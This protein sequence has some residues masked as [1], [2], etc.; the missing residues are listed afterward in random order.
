MKVTLAA[1]YDHY[2]DA[3]A[4]VRHLEAAEIPDDDISIIA[5]NI[6]DRYATRMKERGEPGAASG[7][8][9]A[10]ERGGV[11]SELGVLAIPGAGPVLAAGWLI[12]GTGFSTRDGGANGGSGLFASLVDCGVSREDAQIYAEG[13]RRGGAVV[14]VRVEERIASRIRAILESERQ[15]DPKARCRL[16]RAAGWTGFDEN[17]PPYIP[18]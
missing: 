16:Y 11:L 3:E 18:D 2:S 15:V 12:A 10:G 4:V 6:R 9:F 13:V 17:A 1:L 14:T 8:P 5:S 7:A